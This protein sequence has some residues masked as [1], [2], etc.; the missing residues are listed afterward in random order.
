MTVLRTL[1]CSSQQSFFLKELRIRIRNE[2]R[3]QRSVAVGDIVGVGKAV[4]TALQARLVVNG[5]PSHLI[6]LARCQGCS[7]SKSQTMRPRIF[8]AGQQASTI[9]TV[10]QIGNT[11]R[12]L[13]RRARI[14]VVRQLRSRW[15]IIRDGNGLDLDLVF[16]GSG[17]RSG[18]GKVLCGEFNGH[19]ARRRATL[20]I[21]DGLP[22][23]GTFWL[24]T[25]ATF[26]AMSVEHVVASLDTL[27]ATMAMSERVKANGTVSIR[28][29]S[30][31][32]P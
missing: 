20:W 6:M 11:R 9:R 26:Y 15:N 12:A 23:H 16:F 25:Q 14:L 32:R 21:S 30:W 13:V 4:R 22:T 29:S 24:E 8:Q 19:G 10:G 1:L 3:I 5:C 18:A 7:Y 28:R 27:E 2:Q 17:S 31:R